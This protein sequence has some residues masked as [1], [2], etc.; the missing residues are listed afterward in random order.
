MM[1]FHAQYRPSESAFHRQL[2]NVTP[3]I[4]RLFMFSKGE[5]GMPCATLSDSVQRKDHAGLQH[6]T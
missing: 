1:A 2:W 6:S 4:V 5:D 3:D